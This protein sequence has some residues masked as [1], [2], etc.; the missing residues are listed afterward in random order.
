MIAEAL[1]ERLEGIARSTKLRRRGDC[2]SASAFLDAERYGEAE[3][4]IVQFLVEKRGCELITCRVASGEIADSG[5]VHF[6]ILRGVVHEFYGYEEEMVCF[7]RLFHLRDWRGRE[8]C[9]VYADETPSAWWENDLTRQ[10][11]ERG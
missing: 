10:P 7:L 1:L 8:W 11:R 9:A 5:E 6:R 4:V 3:R 2:V